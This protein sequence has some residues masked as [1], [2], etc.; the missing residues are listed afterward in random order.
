M[1]IIQLRFLATKGRIGNFIRWK[2]WSR[3]SHV[4][5]LIA[6][7]A[8]GASGTIGGVGFYSLD[9]KPYKKQAIVSI[10]VSEAQ[11]IK[12]ME[13]LLSK[14]GAEYDYSGI[15]AFL[16]RLNIHEE[17]KWFCSELLI[18][19]LHVAEIIVSTEPSH[20][21]TPEDIW[22]ALSFCKLCE[23]TYDE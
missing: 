19:A 15:K 8:Y 2:T 21:W 22:K 5:V 9:H 14:E 7:E 23:I 12:F 13:E 10:P 1:K 17:D 3:W 18:E 20:K 16:I 4:D 11:Y 6:G